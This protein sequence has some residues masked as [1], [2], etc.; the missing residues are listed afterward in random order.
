MSRNV[1]QPTANVVAVAFSTSASVAAG[2]GVLLGNLFG[3]A[4]NDI[5][6]T[7]AAPALGASLR[8]RGVVQIA[9]AGSL[10]VGIGDALYWDDSGKVVNKTNTTKEVGIAM[11]STSNGAGETSVLMEIVQTIRNATAS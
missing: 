10:A 1:R 7:S 8:V 4:E 11:S 9:K 5:V 2:G 3:V 6:S